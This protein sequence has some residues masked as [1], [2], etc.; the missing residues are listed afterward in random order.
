MF[1]YELDH[2]REAAVVYELFHHQ[3]RNMSP[4]T[5][6][7]RHSFAQPDQHFCALVREQTYISLTGT[8]SLEEVNKVR[9]PLPWDGECVTRNTRAVLEVRLLL[10]GWSSSPEKLR[11]SFHPKTFFAY[12]INW[13]CLC[14]EQTH[15]YSVPGRYKNN[16]LAKQE[17]HPANLG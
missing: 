8:S 17:W 9:R 15:T 3:E 7:R 2:G 14:D 4:E 16:P 6:L 5:C 11:A 1:T 10:A 13:K 12:Y